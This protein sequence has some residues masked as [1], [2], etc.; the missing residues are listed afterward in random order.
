VPTALGILLAAAVLFAV[1]IV[2]CAR[3]SDR[4]GRRRVM[5]WGNAA[6]VGWSVVFFPLL[7][8]R[9][10]PLMT[11]AVC[12]M[13]IVQG[14]YIGTQPAVFAELFPPAIRFSGA[15][16]ALTL[17][18]IVG[19]APAPFVATALFTA[20]GNSRLITAY[21]VATAVVSLVCTAALKEPVPHLAET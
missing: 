10:L 14:A 11:V 13:L 17:G 3:W 8:T 6:L 5:L 20:A 16:L 1:S 4:L 19:G 12:V 15:S 7:D 18:T 2:V 9:S 21:A